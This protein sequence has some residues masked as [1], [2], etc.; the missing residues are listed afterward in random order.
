[1]KY[2]F[3]TLLVCCHY[4]VCSQATDSIKFKRTSIGFVFSPDYCYRVLHYEQNNKW[5]ADLRNKQETPAFGYTTGFALKFDLTEK[6]SFETGL[7]YSVKGEQTKYVD[8][9]WKS[10]DS[11]YASKTKTK[12]QF[13]YLELPL[14][15]SRAFGKG[16]LSFFAKAGVSINLFTQLRTN[17]ISILGNGDKMTSSSDVD[18]GYSK[19]NIAA[20]LGLGIK[21]CFQ[22]DYQH[23][24]NLFTG[25]S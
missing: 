17:V 3:L 19:I 15:V 14:S 16:K 5:I 2:V 1:M 12:F 7:F 21:M 8:L 22:G 24:S 20:T 23:M 25:D 9:I 6:T 4:C 18:L 11:N 13:T 10:P